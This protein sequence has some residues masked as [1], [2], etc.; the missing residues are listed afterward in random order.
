MARAYPLETFDTRDPNFD[1]KRLS[2]TF[3]MQC[4][5]HETVLTT[6]ATVAATRLLLA[7]ADRI[8]ARR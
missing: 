7:E 2:R 5:M 6:R 1:W 3:Q 8:L 4:E